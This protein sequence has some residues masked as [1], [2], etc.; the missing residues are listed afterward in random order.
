MPVCRYARKIEAAYRKFEAENLYFDY[1]ETGAT[2]VRELG[3]PDAPAEAL[4]LT[5]S[6]TDWVTKRSAACTLDDPKVMN[7]VFSDDV[8]VEDSNSELIEVGSSAQSWCGSRSTSLPAS[9]DSTRSG[10]PSGSDFRKTNASEVAAQTGATFVGELE[11]A[12]RI[13]RTGG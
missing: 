11:S 10:R 13:W 9:R 8:L 5:V 3:Q 4:G 2:G 7:A 6:T 12:A 1:A